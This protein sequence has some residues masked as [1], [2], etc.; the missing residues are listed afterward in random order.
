M[1]GKRRVKAFSRK[2][3][4][5]PVQEKRKIAWRNGT[6]GDILFQHYV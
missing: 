5:K 1:T 2:L 4:K 6:K 3:K